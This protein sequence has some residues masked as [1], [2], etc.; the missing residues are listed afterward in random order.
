MMIA[1]RRR[2]IDGLLYRRR[3]NTGQASGCQ[4]KFIVSDHSG[5][6]IDWVVDSLALEGYS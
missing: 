1:G 5:S 2:R 6:G 4:L 3:T